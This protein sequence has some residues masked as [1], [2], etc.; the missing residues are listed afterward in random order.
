MYEP[1]V[2]CSH[3][4]G[5]VV[6]LLG[7]G[8]AHADPL[9]VHTA[10]Q[11]RPRDLRDISAEQRL[12]AADAVSES[13]RAVAPETLSAL[14]TRT[15]VQTLVP[16]GLAC[17]APACAGA[18]TTP[19][20]AR[21]V[22]LVRLSAPRRGRLRVWV[23]LV[24]RQGAVTAQQEAEEA[25]AAWPEALALARE[26]ARPL[27]ET[28]RTATPTPTPSPQVVAAPSPAPIEAPSPPPAAPPAV[29]T[30]TYRR[31]L[32]AA[33]G[34]GLAALGVTLATAGIVSVLRDGDVAATLPDNV[35][36]VYV[37]GARDYALLGVG[38]AAAV[39]GVVLLVDGLRPRTRMASTARLAPGVTVSTQAFTLTLGARF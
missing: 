30:V 20:N 9:P 11:L 4:T 3:V 33:V 5:L 2:R 25:I 21:A 7:S 32:E 39:T 14:E 6:A 16:D 31:P 18:L 27:V 23:G 36:R 29:S 35:E 13:L 26:T 8:A 34:G 10:T 17:D 28:L 15:R 37:A 24:D 38:A 1:A 19:L 22:V 12:Q